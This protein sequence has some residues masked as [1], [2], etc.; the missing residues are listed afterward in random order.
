[1][2]IDITKWVGRCQP[3][4]ESRPDPPTAPVWEWER[5]QGPWSRI[6]IDFAGPFH[7]QT[8]MVIV[9]A[10]SKWLEIKLMRATTTDA[11]IKELRQLFPTHGLPDVLVLDNGPQFTA[12]QFEGYLADLGVRHVLSA[13][14]HPASN[15]QA[16]RFVRTAKEALSRLG[17]GDWQERIDQFLM[18][19]HTTPCTATGR[20]PVELLMGRK[21]QGLFR[22]N[23]PPKSY[24]SSQADSATLFPGPG[25]FGGDFKPQQQLGHTPPNPQSNRPISRASRLLSHLEGRCHPS[26]GAPIAIL[27]AALPSM[28]QSRQGMAHPNCQTFGMLNVGPKI[29]KSASNIPKVLHSLIGLSSKPLGGPPSRACA[30]K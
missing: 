2:D 10:F 3:C 9:D 8:F 22:A 27:I 5:P 11:V 25:L 30:G 14:F 19:Q 29:V 18:A 12:T 23:S 17:P 1:M 24:P 28:S 15:G 7:G 6:H 13:P 20:S 16:E 4:Q 21:L 26:P